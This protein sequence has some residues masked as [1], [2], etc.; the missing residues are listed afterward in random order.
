MKRENENIKVIDM[1]YC[2]NCKWEHDGLFDKGNLS[3]LAQKHANKKGHIVTREIARII[4]YN[5][6]NL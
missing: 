3:Y 4:Y 1:I 6:T 5:P 2:K